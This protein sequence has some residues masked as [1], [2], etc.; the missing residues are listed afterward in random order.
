MS[1]SIYTIAVEAP[2]KEPLSYLPPAEGN[3]PTRGQSVQV[4]LGSKKVN[5]VVVGQTTELPE[6]K[7]KPIFQVIEDRPALHE[8][9]LKWA[10]W[11]AKYYFHPLGLVF[12]SVFPALPR[13]A[14]RKKK[15]VPTP[16]PLR[17]PQKPP[18]L[19]DEQAACLKSIRETPGFG[20]HLL[21]GVTGSGKTEVYLHLM[22]DVLKAGKQALM[23]VPEISLT[24]QLTDRF[25]KRFPGQ[26]AIIH[27]QLTPRDRT[28]QWWSMVAKEKSILIGARSALFCPLENLGLIVV[29]E[30]HEP[31]YKQEE[32]LKYHGRDAAIMLAN[33]SKCPIILGSATP[34]LETWNN[35]RDGKYQLHEMKKRVADRSLPNIEVVDLRDEK[36]Q[37]RDKINELPFWLSD[38]LYEAMLAT[39]DKKEQVALF[40]NRRGMA[41]MA[42]CPSC[43]HVE[44]CPNC[45]VSLTVHGRDH[46]VCHYCGYTQAKSKKCPACKEGDLVPLGIGTELIET[47]LRKLF[48]EARI[49][50]ADRDEIQ[51][52]DE[53]EKMIRDMEV[54]EIDILI[55]TQMIAKG[56]DF[57]HLTL[58]GLVMADIGFHWPDFRASERS[59]QLLTQVSGRAGRHSVEPGTVIVQTYNPFHPSIVH[60]VQNSFAEFADHE[61]EERRRSGY[62]PFERLA[63]L[64]INSNDNLRAQTVAQRL[65][66]RAEA[67]AQSQERYKGIKVLGPAPAPLAKLRGRF[68][69]HVL[70]KAPA[71]NVLQNFILWCLA[72]DKWILPGTKVQV[73]VDPLHML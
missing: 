30:E 11:M 52:R 40:L 45:A 63:L 20:V 6:F 36:E 72:D 69:Y 42:Q 59:F 39:L 64:R 16:P 22:E 56:L 50:R 37:R 43:G 38:R 14:K 23:L 4:P 58:V 65:A 67:L 17:E 46:L 41:P 44:E 48:P 35:V 47:D 57:P 71:P 1:D 55:G 12:D 19:T 49:A 5:G 3:A 60:T 28:D 32:K 7:L 25:S 66:E 13:F 70:I 53:L 18:I 34:S 2:L 33:L 27:S 24:P 21:Y 9:F 54:R 26:V 8:A 15:A 73:D 29:D 62:P 10:E 51:T 68:R 31:S 61:L